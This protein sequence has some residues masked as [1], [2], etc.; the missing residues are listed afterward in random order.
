M[1]SAEKSSIEKSSLEMSS[2]EKSS[3]EMSSLE[4]CTIEFC[5]KNA[6]LVEIHNYKDYIIRK[7]FAN[8]GIILVCG[9]PLNARGLLYGEAI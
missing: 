9:H 8:S 3:V 5:P 7:S 1:S 6:D 4:M 2:A